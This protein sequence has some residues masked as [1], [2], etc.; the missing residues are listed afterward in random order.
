MPEGEGVAIGASWSFNKEW[1]IFG[2]TGQSRGGASLMKRST[3]IGISHI[4]K[5]YFDVFGLAVNYAEP[6]D[7]QLSD[8]ATMETFLKI[9]LAQNIAITPSFQLLINPALNPQQDH[10]QVVGLRLRLTL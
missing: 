5:A 10:I 9:Q 1:I 3:T 7:Q 8:Q 2:R 6:A 4:W